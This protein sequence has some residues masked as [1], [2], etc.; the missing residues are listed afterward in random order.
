MPALATQANP[1][2]PSENSHFIMLYNQR[3][4]NIPAKSLAVNAYPRQY[5][6]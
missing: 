2:V 3:V 1:K 5:F 4:F 6:E